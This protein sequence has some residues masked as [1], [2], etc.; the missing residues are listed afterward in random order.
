M[1]LILPCPFPTIKDTFLAILDVKT[2]SI[3]VSKSTSRKVYIMICHTI[4]LFIF[5]DIDLNNTYVKAQ[6]HTE[7]KR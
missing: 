1:F 7:S 4:M 3:S 6:G 5:M 2:S